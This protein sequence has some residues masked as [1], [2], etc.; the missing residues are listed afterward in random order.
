MRLMRIF[1]FYTFINKIEIAIITTDF[2]FSY[3]K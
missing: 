2:T 1:C 3:V